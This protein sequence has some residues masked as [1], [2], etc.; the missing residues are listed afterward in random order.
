MTKLLHAG[1]RT[2]ASCSSPLKWLVLLAYVPSFL[3][4]YKCLTPLLP[5][6]RAAE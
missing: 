6:P 4:P 2:H 1:Q 3:I 5:S